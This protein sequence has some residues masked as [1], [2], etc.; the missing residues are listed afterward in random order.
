V[1]LA[2]V[3]AIPVNKLLLQESNQLIGINML[4]SDFLKIFVS[5]CQFQ[6]AGKMTVSPPLQTPWKV[7]HGVSLKS[8]MSL[9]KLQVTWQPYLQS[10][11]QQ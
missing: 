1:K 9:K 5:W 11:L 10:I 2:L 8:K 7:A 4:T 6:G 3:S